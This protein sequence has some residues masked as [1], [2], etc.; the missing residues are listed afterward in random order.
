MT[1][2]KLTQEVASYLI[3]RVIIQAQDNWIK[4]DD[5]NIIYLED[6][7]IQMLNQ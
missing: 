5:G 3:G 2:E 1:T 4:L 6:D 7:E